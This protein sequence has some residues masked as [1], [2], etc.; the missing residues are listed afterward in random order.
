MALNV[1]AFPNA[2][3]VELR[4][5][6]QPMQIRTVRAYN[7][8]YTRHNLCAMAGRSPNVFARQVRKARIYQGIP[9]I[10][11]KRK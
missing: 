5:R 4:T 8:Q 11:Y 1:T 7:Q 6:G 3:H 9:V 10:D 2:E